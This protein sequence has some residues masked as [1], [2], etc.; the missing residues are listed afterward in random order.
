MPVTCVHF[1]FDHSGF[2]ENIPIRIFHNQRPIPLHIR[3]NTFEGDATLLRRQV[4]NVT[5]T[6]DQMVLVCLARLQLVFLSV[7]ASGY[8]TS[9]SKIRIVGNPTNL[10]NLSM[11]RYELRCELFVLSDVVLGLGLRMDIN[12]ASYNISFYFFGE[13]E[14]QN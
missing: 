14:F 10:K 6:T 2:L 9:R 3:I 4:H 13:G 12:H 8:T 11:S 5:E 7:W 1:W